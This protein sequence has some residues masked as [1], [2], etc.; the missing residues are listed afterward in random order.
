MGYTCHNYINSL[1]IKDCLGETAIYMLY[2]TPNLSPKDR[3]HAIHLHLPCGRCLAKYFLNTYFS[4][5]FLAIFVQILLYWSQLHLAQNLL[6]TQT[7]IIL[8]NIRKTM[9]ICL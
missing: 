6:Y 4:L 3:N 5:V 7:A 2:Y 1:Q 9:L 8:D